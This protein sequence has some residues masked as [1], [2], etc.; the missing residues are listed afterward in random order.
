MM[1]LSTLALAGPGVTMMPPSIATHTLCT[2]ILP[3]F[4]STEI[5]TT[6]APSEAERSVIEMPSARPSGRFAFQSHICATVSKHLARLG[7]GAHALEPELDRVHALVDRHLV[8]EA[9]DREHVEHVADRAP[10]LELDAVRDAAPLDVLV[11]HAVVGD[12]DAA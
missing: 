10:V 1:A 9:L 6:P 5:S 11:G 7:R 3:L 8:D 4:W 12:L 2:W